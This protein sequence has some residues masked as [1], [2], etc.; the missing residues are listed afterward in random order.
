M[1]RPAATLDRTHVCWRR[2]PRFTVA[3]R[4]VLAR[5]QATGRGPA[6]RRLRERARIDERWRLRLEQDQWLLDA[7]GPVAMVDPTLAAS[8]VATPADDDERL[9]AEAVLELAAADAAAHD[10]DELTDAAGPAGQRLAELAVIDGR[11]APGVIE[12]VLRELIR[13]WDDPARDARRWGGLLERATV[14]AVQQLLHPATIYANATMVLRDATLEHWQP[15]ALRQT[16]AGPVLE[17]ELSVIALRY[18]RVKDVASVRSP[19]SKTRR[20][21]INLRWS[22]VLDPSPEHLWRLTA[23]SNPAVDI[24]GA[25]P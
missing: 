10:I 23:T 24:P 25:M 6:A 12:S 9:R 17:I 19:G 16:G 22:L 11:F 13:A 1:L 21:R 3:G 15:V 5:V 7:Y 20:R 4:L 8:Q 14:E 2:G 18:L